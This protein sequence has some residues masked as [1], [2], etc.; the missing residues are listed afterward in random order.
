LQST[1]PDTIQ[2]VESFET[3]I[4]NQPGVITYCVSTSSIDID[5]TPVIKTFAKELLLEGLHALKPLERTDVDN[6]VAH[7]D[8]VKAVVVNRSG[9]ILSASTILKS[10]FFVNLQKMSLPEYVMTLSL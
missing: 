9:S 1:T 3:F 6:G 5:G 2:S 10:D 4:E 7:P 8:E